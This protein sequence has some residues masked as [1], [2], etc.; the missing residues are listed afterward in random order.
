MSDLTEAEIF[1]CLVTNFR[2][3]A[4]HCDDLAR[5]PK[6]GPTYLKFRAELKLIE[7]ACRQA[8]YWRSDARWLQI[9]LM[10]EEAHRRAGDWLRGVKGPDGHRRP[11]PQGTLHPLFVKLAEN[12]RLGLARAQEFKDKKTGRMG[13]ILPIV[14]ADP[15]FERRTFGYRQT[16]GGII[17]PDGVSAA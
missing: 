13:A 15:N 3:A 5:L 6:K 2:L 4:E 9:G 11:I 14:Q 17:L 1:S 12:L 16:A 7:G 10:M 8:A